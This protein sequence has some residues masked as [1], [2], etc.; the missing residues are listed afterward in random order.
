MVFLLAKRLSLPWPIPLVAALL[1]AMQKDFFTVS[2]R[3]EPY[4]FYTLLLMIALW[5]YYNLTSPAS[6]LALGIVLGYAAMTRQEG[7]A[8]AL[9]LG[10]ASLFR[11]KKLWLKGYMLTFL[12]ALLIITPFLVTNTLERGHPFASPYFEGERLQI[13]DSWGA[14]QDSLGATWGIIGSLWKP[15][16][17]ELVRPSFSH[18][19]LWIGFIIPLLLLIASWGTSQQKQ[20]NKQQPVAAVVLT[21]CLFVLLSVMSTAYLF[22]HAVAEEYITVALAGALL[23]SIIPFIFATRGHGAVVIAILI[24]QILIATWF[25][26][27][28]K[29]YQQDYPLLMLILATGLL[30]PPRLLHPKL[31]PMSLAIQTLLILMPVALI[32]VAL[33]N[34]ANLF[35]D[36]W[37][38]ENAFD[39]V[40]YRAAKTAQHLPGPYA[41][42]QAYLPALLFFEKNVHVAS[43]SD[44]S[45]PALEKQWLTDHRIRTLVIDN[46]HASFTKPDPSWLKVAEYKAEGRQKQFFIVTVYTIDSAQ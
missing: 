46:A 4:T 12:P 28:P 36:R 41:F 33:I 38:T 8:L 15:S 7:F 5:L 13:V 37:N 32:T 21:L 20:G 17:E 6:Q 24:T 31:A 45:S 22:N 16:W 19:T 29:H 34:K 25:H 2:L 3:P 27:F 39:S 44:H 1:L 30:F 26:P 18:P 40:M 10:L 42:E 35:I 23:G 9:V 43:L 11:W 14:F